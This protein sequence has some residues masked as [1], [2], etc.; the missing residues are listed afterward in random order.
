MKRLTGVAFGQSETLYEYD[1]AG[2][3]TKL[4]RADGSVENRQLDA[5][6]QLACITGESGAPLRE[7]SCDAQGNLVEETRHH[8]GGAEVI[9]YSYDALNRLTGSTRTPP[10]AYQ[11]DS[12]GNI[13]LETRGGVS[14]ESAFN[15]RNQLVE[16]AIAGIERRVFTYDGRGNLV[17]EEREDPQSAQPALEAVA[18]YAYGSEGRM[19]AGANES[20]V[21]SSYSYNGLGQL[22]GRDTRILVPDYAAKV[23]VTLQDGGA[24]YVYGLGRILRSSGNE[25]LVYHNDRLGS[26]ERLTDLS[27]A[28]SGSVSYDEWGRPSVAAPG[29][30]PNYT[31]HEYDPV[32]GIYFA[33]ARMYDPNAK[34]FLETDPALNDYNFYAYCKSNP[35]RYINV[36]SEPIMG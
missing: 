22:A 34:R 1:L 17:L 6:G 2:R 30:N 10:S 13:A 3:L 16:K 23:P 29:L 32:L 14:S 15:S 8:P 4:T 21:S 19:A 28:M 20:G 31:R 12:L 33:Q 18:S 25:T 5:A 27:G 7:Y 26:A 11:Y 35:L 24:K 9:E 36:K